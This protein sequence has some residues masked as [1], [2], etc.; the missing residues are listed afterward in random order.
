MNATGVE[1]NFSRAPF[2]TDL[3]PASCRAPASRPERLQGM[4]RKEKAPRE[5]Q[6]AFCRK[7]IFGLRSILADAII[8]N[9]IKLSG[10]THDKFRPYSL[11]YCF[12]YPQLS[13]LCS[14]SPDGSCVRGLDR[15]AA[16][17][18]HA[19]H[20]YYWGL[21]KQCNEGNP[22]KLLLV[23][24]YGRN[25]ASLEYFPLHYFCRGQ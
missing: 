9:A 14:F 25:L 10:F 22:A 23:L 7:A 18:W 8:R 11:V 1:V 16:W 6:G 2:Y 4:R 19:L 13:G 3:H 17:W 24:N 5:Y 15:R 12:I 20:D 21:H